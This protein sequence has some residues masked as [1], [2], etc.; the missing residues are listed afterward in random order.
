MPAEKKREPCPALWPLLLLCA[1]LAAWIDFGSLHRRHHADSLLPALISLYRWT[2]F[3]WELDRVGMLV[4]LIA[5]PVKH[6]LFNLLLQDGLYVFCGLSALTLL[7]RYLLR[8]ATFPAASVL[9]VAAFLA[10]T[11]EYYRFEYLIDTQYGVWFFLGLSSLVLLEPPPS[12]SLS[13][14]RRIAAV[15]LMILAHWVYCTST[16]FLG[17]LIVFRAIFCPSG[18]AAMLFGFCRTTDAPVGCERQERYSLGA[19]WQTLRQN[20]AASELGRS[21]VVLAIG[22][23]A[24][25]C[26]MRLAPIHDTNFASLPAND[27]PKTWA[28]LAT[29]SW[30][31]LAP[32]RWPWFLLS[33]AALGLAGYCSPSIRSAA[34]ENWRAAVAALAAALMIGMFIG[35]RHWVVANG[36]AFRFLLLS[37]LMTQAALLGIA[38]APL[39]AIKLNPRLVYRCAALPV[40]FGAA[41]VGYGWPSLD[42]VYQDLDPYY[43]TAA[44]PS[45]IGTQ[46]LIDCGCT[47]VAGDYWKVWP[48]M[49]RANLALYERG[50]R[51][52]IWGVSLRSQPT[53]R[54][55]SKIPR[56]RMRVA[57][58]A[59]GDPEADA[60]FAHYGLAPLAVSEK[61]ASLWLLAPPEVLA[62]GATQKRS[63][64]IAR[65]PGER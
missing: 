57:V 59:G 9:S 61:L 16:L 29:T 33:V 35:T 22:F 53:Y 64:E 43:I 15:A 14:T 39:A 63:V 4:P 19:V 2:P 51:R 54:Y 42:G 10:L 23:I 3:Y 37:A 62:A 18:V 32:Q 1:A 47:H 58:A 52:M 56:E 48:A 60:Y 31:S 25:L 26:L 7:P 65:Q 24:G 8:N 41:L 38:V 45:G 13:W 17:P 50:E 6:P 40:A 30:S 55:W 46:E 34:R 28:S 12:G 11:P 21:L 36:Y 5:R 49:F 20:A 27:W 44:P